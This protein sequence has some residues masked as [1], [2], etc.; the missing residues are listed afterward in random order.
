[1][2]RFPDTFE[3]FAIVTGVLPS[4]HFE[5]RGAIVRIAKPNRI[6]KRPVNKL[7]P[8]E[9]IYQDTNQTDKPRG[10]KFRQEAAVIGKLKKI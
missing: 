10:Q 1:M 6:L 3:E 8:I 9:N 2:K 7:F 4:K 5:I